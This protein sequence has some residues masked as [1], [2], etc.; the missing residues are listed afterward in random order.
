M[1]LYFGLL[2]LL[3]FNPYSDDILIMVDCIF[4]YSSCVSSD[5]FLIEEYGTMKTE[6]KGDGNDSLFL[7]R[8]IR[9]RVSGIMIGTRSL[10]FREVVQTV[11]M[12]CLSE[13]TV[14][15]AVVMSIISSLPTYCDTDFISMSA[16]F[17]RCARMPSTSPVSL[18]HPK[19]R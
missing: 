14:S 2:V 13:D 6:G 19:L 10:Q 12:S 15:S 8:R 3:S 17:C 9:R 7:H 4:E 5:N 11:C 16:R 18:S 1:V